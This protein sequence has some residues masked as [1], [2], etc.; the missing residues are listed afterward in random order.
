VWRDME[1]FD[2]SGGA[3]PAFPDRFF[4]QI[5]DA[6][7]ASTN[8]T[9][10]RVGDAECYLLDARGLLEFALRAMLSVVGGASRR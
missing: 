6:Y 3:H 1:E 10:G 9:G 5:V 2:T 8:N 4:A 7:L